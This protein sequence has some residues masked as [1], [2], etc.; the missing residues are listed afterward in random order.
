MCN[1]THFTLSMSVL[2]APLTVVEKMRSSA[3]GIPA[4]LFSRIDVKRAWA[5]VT[6]SKLGYRMWNVY[7]RGGVALLQNSGVEKNSRG[8]V[9]LFLT[10][11][12]KLQVEF[13]CCVVKSRTPA[14]L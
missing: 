4:I 14:W 1:A 5:T 11:S 12:H 3:I 7:V 10:L 9:S 2:G 6:R 13:S 8:K